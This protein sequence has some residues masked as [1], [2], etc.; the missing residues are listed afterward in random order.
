MNGLR[1]IVLPPEASKKLRVWIRS[2]HLICEGNFFIF[3]TVESSAID[4]FSECIRSLGGTVISVQPVKKVWIGSHRRVLLQRVKA[5]LL[6]PNNDLK[7]Y[8]IKFG[9]L[10]TRFDERA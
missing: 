10:R 9:G 2:R 5:S 4:R 8:W 1:E 3:E 7:Q 6:V